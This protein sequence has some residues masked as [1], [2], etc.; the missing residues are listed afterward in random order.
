MRGARGARGAAAR[1]GRLKRR[2]KREDDARALDVDD[3]SRARARV[4][5][6]SVL[7]DVIGAVGASVIQAAT[8]AVIENVAVSNEGERVTF[9]ATTRGTTLSLTLRRDS[10]IAA[11]AR[12]QSLG[13]RGRDGER[14]RR[15][16]T[17]TRAW[18]RSVDVPTKARR[19]TP[20]EPPFARSGRCVTDV[21]AS[22]SCRQTMI[23]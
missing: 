5:L 1:G 17:R 10:E 22:S 2:A 16:T 7:S 19:R 3:D 20:A 13:R 11:G 23:C 8:A 18:K 12:I 21:C 15:R 4:A 14:R 6:V 9:D